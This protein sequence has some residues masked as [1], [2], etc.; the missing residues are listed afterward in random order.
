[1]PLKNLS[2]LV[3]AQGRPFS[4]AGFTNWFRDMVREAGLPDGLSP[5]G[6]RKATCRRLAEAGCTPH[7][8][9]AIS[10]HKSLAEVTRY[11]VAAGRKDLAV[12][13]MLALD[14]KEA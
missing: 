10:G 5:H 8:I 13:A 9:M 6:L 7:Q 1:M 12:Q 11:T 3:T 14:R 4:P 2:F